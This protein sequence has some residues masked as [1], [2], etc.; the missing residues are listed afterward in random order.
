MRLKPVIAPCPMGLTPTSPVITEGGTVLT[1]LL[2]RIAKS[3]AVPRLTVP[4][5]CGRVRMLML[6]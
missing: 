2:A 5:P 6:F 4:G 3:P 1:P